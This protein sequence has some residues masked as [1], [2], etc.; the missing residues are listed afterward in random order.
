MAFAVSRWRRSFRSST[1]AFSGSGELI[2]VEVAAD[3]FDQIRLT[4]A[5]MTRIDD[6]ERI[7]NF[8]KVI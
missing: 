4:G 3:M 2:S 8:A 1:R 6:T 7:T 5:E